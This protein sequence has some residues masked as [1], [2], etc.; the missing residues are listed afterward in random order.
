MN[1]LLV[2]TFYYKNKYRNINNLGNKTFLYL[3]CLSVKQESSRTASA[4]TDSQWNKRQDTCFAREDQ[5]RLAVNHNTSDGFDIRSVLHG[6]VSLAA[7]YHI[8]VFYEITNGCKSIT[9]H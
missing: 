6:Q 4:N 9:I 3:I 5:A 2:F 7:V 1:Q 8:Y